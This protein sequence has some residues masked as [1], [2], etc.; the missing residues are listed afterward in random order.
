VLN[1]KAD[2][3]FKGLRALVVD[4]SEAARE[5]LQRILE[6]SGFEVIPARDG[7]QAIEISKKDPA[8]FNVALID[9]VMAGVDGVST[10]REISRIQGR[11][12][13][14]LIPMSA[15]VTPEIERACAQAGAYPATLRKPYRAEQVATLLAKALGRNLAPVASRA[16]PSRRNHGL[17]LQG[18]D[19][20]S[21]IDRCG[22]DIPLYRKLIFGF[23]TSGTQQIEQAIEQLRHAE[24]NAAITTMHN[25]RGELLNLGM[26]ELVAN[27]LTI[28]SE[29]TP[30]S[31]P[32]VSPMV[33]GVG[34]KFAHQAARLSNLRQDLLATLQRIQ[35]LP[36]LSIDRGPAAAAAAPE[37]I[38][39]KDHSLA[40]LTSLMSVNDPAAIALLPA[41]G[42]VLP[43]HY[44]Q[45]QQELFRSHFDGLEFDAALQILRPQDIHHDSVEPAPDGF[46]ILV[47]DDAA[48]TVR[49][50]CRAL[51][52]MGAL[53]FALSGEKA[54][55]IA[56]RWHPDLV[57][58]D[59]SMG[60]IS[61]IELCRRIK[62]VPELADCTVMLISTN[63]DVA[64]EVEGLTAGAADFIEKPL[65]T[66]R[67]VG[68]VSAQLAMLRRRAESSAMHG[69]I[70]HDSASGFI[71][72]DLT[73]QVLAISPSLARWLGRSTEP[74]PGLLA[75]DLFDPAFF[76]AI[77][78]AIRTHSRGGR[79]GPL[80]T[81]MTS[82]T[83]A[84][85]PVRLIGRDMPGHQARVLWFG[86]E[87]I[88][89]R[90][91]RERSRNDAQLNEKIGVLASGIAHEFN[92]LLG[93]VIGRIDMAID[94][95]KDPQIGMH[96]SR[97]NEAALRAATISRSLRGSAEQ[98]SR[99][100]REVFSVAAL[101]DQY[102]PVLRNLVP[103]SIALERESSDTSLAILIEPNDLLDML[104]RII[105]NAA[106][107]SRP[108]G[109]ILVRVRTAGASDT[110]AQAGSVLLE[111][112][113]QGVGMS[114]HTVSSAFDAFYTTKASGR[115]GLGL[116]DVANLAERN[117]ARASIDSKPGLGTTVRITFPRA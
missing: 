4:D 25:L 76:S 34:G 71:T 44:D 82:A 92:N 63:D 86:I 85:L 37:P 79:I 117:S 114:E 87:D 84:R 89:V 27:L 52:G 111:I 90:V 93:V 109:R 50:L 56:S 55:E 46:R 95:N 88:S 16:V 49:L 42:P 6:R 39:D 38:E 48:V 8:A 112:S 5:I 104:M 98:Q 70:S 43:A 58:S 108:G 77:D 13:V 10:I 61:G 21:A 116:S 15:S 103:N 1:S 36:G 47:V 12:R 51:E 22:G 18:C 11:A 2:K 20:E 3:P 74:Q 110:D 105:E 97:A 35:R 75:Q 78:Q 28:L 100:E 60:G 67:I 30:G 23:Q 40:A 99:G 115:A 17:I 106:E 19:I 96:L 101:L 65:N 57:I 59:V 94:L 83:G 33:I 69:A 31:S 91:R 73:G 81:S 80:E 72:C 45:P 113:D 29:L 26:V 41:K 62:S 107:A 64:L 14:P 24:L 102:W 54:F 68:R 9:L 32:L 7:E 53:R 66:P